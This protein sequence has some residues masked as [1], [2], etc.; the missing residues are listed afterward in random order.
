MKAKSDFRTT[1]AAALL[2]G[3]IGSLSA[4][5]HGAGVAMVTDLQ[6]NA[7][8][9]ID[10]QSRNVGI[11]AE[12]D[13]DARIK[14]AAGATLVVLYLDAGDEYAFKGPATIDFKAGAPETMSGAP[15]ERRGPALG[16]DVRD[17]RIKPVGV[18]QGAM[19][20]RAIRPETRIRL[21]SPNN[22]RTLETRPVFSWV[23]LDP[24]LK[25]A[26]EL[27]DDTGHSMI[28]TQVEATSFA[29]PADVQIVEGA[30]YSWRVST[31]LPNGRK[32]SS[33]SEFAVAATDLR[34]KA[35]ALRPAASAP[36]SRRIVYAAWL[37][38]MELKDEARKYWQAAA[39]E[40]PGDAQ[41]KALAEE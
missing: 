7:T 9:S 35:R 21:L 19:V 29:L 5:A 11:L 10:G 23:P 6:G 39:A 14:L 41:L 40:R 1:L 30:L 24:G 17:V 31:R 33:T 18:R 13:A 32:Y 34:T 16:K 36:L 3:A 22:T 25:Y 26:F 38:Q 20:M 8:T 27:T 37:D 4:L 28:E 2:A 15:P 12:L